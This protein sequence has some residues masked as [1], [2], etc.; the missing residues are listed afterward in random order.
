V[1]ETQS[2]KEGLDGGKGK[3]IELDFD[4]QENSTKF[5]VLSI[6]KVGTIYYYRIV[7]HQTFASNH[8][9]C[10]PTPSTF[11]ISI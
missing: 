7:F 2:D 6:S 3:G 5:V 10:T 4:L 11:P 9:N 8:A 1:S